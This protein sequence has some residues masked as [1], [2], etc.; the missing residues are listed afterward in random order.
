MTTEKFS[1]YDLL[2]VILLYFEK[3]RLDREGEDIL[4]ILRNHL[5]GN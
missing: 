2:T 3:T 5:W 1:D 4:D